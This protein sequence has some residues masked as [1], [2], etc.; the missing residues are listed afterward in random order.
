LSRAFAVLIK[1][2]TIFTVLKSQIAQ[3]H[4]ERARKREGGEMKIRM[5]RKG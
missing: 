3:I 2:K 5:G 4:A 1:A